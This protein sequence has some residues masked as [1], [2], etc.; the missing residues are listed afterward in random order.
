MPE[1]KH[2]YNALLGN[3]PAEVA[4]LVAQAMADRDLRRRIGR[5]GVETLQ[6]VYSPSVV[7]RTLIER[8]RAGLGLSCAN[9]AATSNSSQDLS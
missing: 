1:I 3:T 6:R 2:G 4:A 7:T 9:E 5:G 8:M